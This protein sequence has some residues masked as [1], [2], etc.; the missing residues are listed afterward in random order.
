MVII[1]SLFSLVLSVP[2]WITAD[3]SV[4]R[5]LRR[6]GLAGAIVLWCLLISPALGA[7]SLP[8][9]WDGI[10][11]GLLGRGVGILWVIGAGFLAS[12]RESLRPVVR[13]L[14][15]IL[16]V[17]VLAPM[18]A[19][20]GTTV[21]LVWVT[22]WMLDSGTSEAV[23]STGLA[24]LSLI[25]ASGI[26]VAGD[27]ILGGTWSLRI[28]GSLA[29]VG[30]LLGV[31]GQWMSG[32]LISGAASVSL[33]IS[34]VAL[35]CLSVVLSGPLAELL[36]H[37]SGHFVGEALPGVAMW[38]VTGAYVLLK[39]ET[40]SYSATDENIYFY[41]AKL[42]SEGVAP[43]RDFF[44]AH[45]PLH[46]LIPA[47]LVRVFG[48]HFVMLKWVPLVASALSGGFLYLGLRRMGLR[49]G[50]LAAAVAFLFSLEQLQ[51]S[52]NLTGINLTTMF[53][54]AS[55]WALTAQRV[56]LGAL[57]S[58]ASVMTGVYAAAPALALGMV[59]GS[60]S[61][62]RM[63]LYLGLLVTSVAGVV[64]WMVL[65]SGR[66]FVDQVFIFH[67]MKSA[68]EKGHLSPTLTDLSVLALLG[69]GLTGLVGNWMREKKAGGFWVT[70]PLL[71]VA[72]GLAGSFL[73][74]ARVETGDGGTASVTVLP[75]GLTLLW[76]DARLFFEGMEFRRFAV[77]HAH[78]LLGPIILAGV[79]W[80]LKLTR[81][82]VLA[83]SGPVVRSGVVGAL[84][85]TAVLAEL[86]LLK[87]TH[88]FYYVLAIPGGAIALGA[89]VESVVGATAE[90]AKNVATL[91]LSQRL[92]GVSGSLLAVMLLFVWMPYSH[93]MAMV[94]FPEEVS[95][96]ETLQCYEPVS[97]VSTPF[98]P[99][100]R[101]VFGGACRFRGGREPGMY[102]YLWKKTWYFS[103]AERI[104]ATIREKS[105]PDETIAGGSL[106]APLLAL[107][108]DR[109]L[110]GNV[111]DTN[112][113]RIRSGLTRDPDAW[114]A[115]CDENKQLSEDDCRRLAGEAEM[116]ADICRTP[117]RYI[118]AS[119]RTFFDPKRMMNDP[120]VRRNFRPVRL[121][122]EHRL[123]LKGTTPVLLLERI[124]QG[125]DAQG[126]YCR[127]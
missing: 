76:Q 80:A 24:W 73:S 27:S 6:A 56:V 112:S 40:V 84:L 83:P 61:P 69:L 9:L 105:R 66:A 59:A 119:P 28:G 25:W 48:F 78:V 110:A 111:V 85:L 8:S 77:F 72:A 34:A 41:G 113:N 54:L 118:V 10:R 99:A 98:G 3:S 67:F 14:S 114:K 106:T 123:G 95:Q 89:A 31:L 18:S 125:A 12:G 75:G 122:R 21:P 60:T 109:R 42:W 100:V 50:A 117:V 64:W 33:G 120:A 2:L 68:A 94:R 53:V 103:T 108:S 96:A 39:M 55:F 81:V 15:A 35:F 36:K 26:L 104:A 93:G 82:E 11:P 74:G 32:G 101:S 121:F 107:L 22:R 91:G 65:L 62:R 102:H 7:L 71:L 63:W 124:S 1:L 37:P 46:L 126:N 17:L 88:T 19:G 5:N 116:W 47:T 13:G 51:A 52:V 23:L 90:L 58:A 43:Y 16:I 29:A 79:Y 97:N 57:L 44:F 20:S 70:L 45:P 86:A 30:V 127:F 4:H 49:W 92:A 115:Y 38:V 87:K